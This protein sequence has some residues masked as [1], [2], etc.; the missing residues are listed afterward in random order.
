ME[1]TS[2]AKPVVAQPSSANPGEDKQQS[3]KRYDHLRQIE[4]K[5]QEV[6]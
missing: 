6:A 3:R 1:S 2:Q 5:M 4:L